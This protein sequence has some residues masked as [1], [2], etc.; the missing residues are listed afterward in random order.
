MADYE[1]GFSAD[2]TIT[3][4]KYNFF[5]DAGIN[6]DDTAGSAFMGMYWADN[7]YYFPNYQADATICYTNTP[8]RT[9]M[10]APGVVQACFVTELV[11]ERVA[12][13]LGLPT[14]QVQQKNFISDGAMA[15]CGQT[16]TD[17]TLPTVWN[18]LLQRSQYNTRL[19]LVTQYNARN[20]WR[21]RGI[22]ICPVKYG[23]GWAGYNAGV[24][25][26]V[27]QSD[28]TV[29][30]SHSGA[31]I[32]QGINT[33][34]AQAVAMA[35]GIDIK[36][37]RVVSSD[38]DRVVNGGCTG[39]SGTSEVIVQAA[40]NA[41][42][43]LND[44]LA[45]YRNNGR[46]NKT[47]TSDWVALLK[48]LP[49]DISLNVEG[50]YSPNENPNGQFFQYFVY[51]ACVT[52]LELD[53][54]TGEVHVLASEL[55]Y[56]CGQS[57]NPAVDIGQ[58]EG[59]LVMG[60]GYF[61]TERVQYDVDNGQLLTNGTW[62]YKPPLAQDVPSVLN[63]TLLKNKYNESGILGSKA[64]GEPPYVIAN[65][66]YFALKMAVTSARVDAGAGAG[67]FDMEVPATVDVRQQACLV[68][69]ARFVM[70]Y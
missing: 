22:S 23:M 7:A 34:A 56:D 18:T 42:Q 40:L 37:I 46:F 39:G 38:T 49:Y 2:G 53:V 9:S 70:P 65:S 61:L 60:L 4:L 32:G 30:V 10:R 13:E 41:C 51:A 55:V 16:I 54:L 26:G 29:F 17:C 31:E 66:V 11:V 15:I 48:S 3:A 25:V 1:V 68:T 58:I 6:S 45:P 44:R 35:L 33:K 27:N 14:T 24:Q 8:A 50:W 62:E 12:Q 20:L 43:K 69:P 52:E 19:N 5:L 21:K 28:G 59:A 47:A 67:F 36:L 57:L 63:V 64:V